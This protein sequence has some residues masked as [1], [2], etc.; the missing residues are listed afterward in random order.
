VAR[1]VDRL[2]P[3][4]SIEA[5]TLDRHGEVAENQPPHRHLVD[6]GVE[7]VEQQISVVRRLA[8]HLDRVPRGDAGRV[9]DSRGQRK[10]GLFEGGGA[11]RANAADTDVGTMRKQ[12]SM[13][14]DRRSSGHF[15]H[16]SP[17]PLMD[18]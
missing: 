8:S 18:Q 16:R 5:V 15:R 6:Q 14:F 13:W 12:L 2:A 9:G 3:G 1:A 11:R 10:R 17:H 4:P 7:P